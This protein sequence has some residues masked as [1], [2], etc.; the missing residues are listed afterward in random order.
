MGLLKWVTLGIEW[1]SHSL[2]Q[3]GDDWADDKIQVDGVTGCLRACIA[4]RSRNT[5][6]KIILS[7]GGGGGASQHFAN[8]ASSAI[9][10]DVFV[11]SCRRLVDAYNLDGIDGE[12]RDMSS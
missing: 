12:L 1:R 8:I 3:L 5:V 10:T 6:L 4:L 7:V 9:M 11:K 2:K